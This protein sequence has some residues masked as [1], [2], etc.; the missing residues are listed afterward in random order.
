MRRSTMRYAI[1]GVTL[2]ELLTVLA[3]IAILMAVAIPSYSRYVLRSSRT[4]AMAALS[5][6]ASMQEQYRLDHNGY[7]TTLN[8]LLGAHTRLVGSG[9]GAYLIS[10][11][12]RY[13]VHMT[14]ASA[15]AFTFEARNWGNQ[16]NDTECGHFR[17]TSTGIRSVGVGTVESCWR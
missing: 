8:D 1:R 10:E 17:L 12:R 14:A 2:L 3:I 5:W 7:A 16:S 15:N 13:T 4:D 11:Q 9:A 6:L